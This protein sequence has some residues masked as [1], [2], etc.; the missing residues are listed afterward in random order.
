MG[1]KQ[2]ITPMVGLYLT[3]QK[4]LQKN[5][6]KAEKRRLKNNAP[7]TLVFYHRVN[8]P[9]AH[10][11]LTV[12]PE[13][14]GRF[15]LKLEVVPVLLEMTD[16]YYPA[17]ALLEEY[18]LKDGLHLAKLYNLSCPLFEKTPNEQLALLATRILLSPVQDANSLDVMLKIG[19][20]FWMEDRAALELLSKTFHMLDE[21][22]VRKQLKLNQQR[23]EKEG[24]YLSAMLHYG[25][26]WY[27][28]L[29]RLGHLEQR[30]L[31]LGLASQKIQPVYN[32]Q[33]GPHLA[34]HIELMSIDQKPIEQNPGG[35]KIQ[36]RTELDF[37][38]S[39]RS[40][41]SYLA[42]E[43]TFALV[44]KFGIKLN[45]RPVLPMAMRGMQVPYAKR[46]Y[47]VM[48]AKREAIKAGVP[49][50]RICDPLGIGV[51]RAFALFSHA[52]SLQK[53]RA[54]ILSIA[55][56]VWSEGVNI[57]SDRGLRFC[58]ERI[59]LDWQS[60][61]SFLADD[62]WRQIAESNRQEMFRLGNWGVPG[63]RLGELVVWGQ[64]R[65]W[66]L[67]KALCELSL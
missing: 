45:I 62:R 23:L 57:A 21:S 46:I 44:E 53:G 54:Y 38:F 49:F 36:P 55:R 47:I 39:F 11:L 30:L 64:D 8:D 66:V 27:W 1:I 19:N 31:D 40:P 52:E 48:D 7:H 18:A 14:I 59:G 65:F 58:V 13:F 63:F 29:D 60:C 61:K 56:A 50:G 28:G 12:L 20:A 10:L 34:R 22:S 24:H 35:S 3:S 5:R 9:Y 41:Y 51:E 2:W 67:E 4:R 42:I 33:H 32:R 25:G 15:N 26:E 43:R 16:L 6:I 17:P 37:F